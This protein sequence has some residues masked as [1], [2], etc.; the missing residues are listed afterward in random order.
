MCFA[1]GLHLAVLDVLYKKDV[2]VQVSVNIEAEEIDDWAEDWADDWAEDVDGIGPE[3][4]E[5]FTDSIMQ[6]KTPNVIFEATE[7]CSIKQ[8]IDKIRQVVKRF[9]VSPTKN[10][11]IL[12]VR[13]LECHKKNLV[14]M[15]DCRT[16]WNSTLS[17]IRR[18]LFMRKSIS[19]ALVDSG[20]QINFTNYEWDLM[21][22]IVKCLDPIEIAIK[23]LCKSN[24]SLVKADLIFSTLLN[25]IPTNGE[26]EGLMHGAL[27]TRINQRRNMTSI[28]L[29]FLHSNN[30]IVLNENLETAN[31]SEISEFLSSLYKRTHPSAE[32]VAEEREDSLD[33][34]IFDEG[35]D[36]EF[37][38]VLNK[39]TEKAFA[40]NLNNTIDPHSI[41]DNIKKEMDVFTA[42][43]SKGSMLKFC[44]EALS[45]IQP[46]SCENE[47]N[48]SAAG[49]I[50]NKLSTR[51]G[52]KSINALTML[53]GHFK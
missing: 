31:S 41:T 13:V 27:V 14:L 44:Y 7:A 32:P 9:R 51:L 3:E 21:K 30:Q 19:L 20:D 26:F 10:D 15:L 40:I 2:Q 18:F 52:D 36:L 43:G 42:T 11:S 12:Q 45:T 4:V 35:E 16:R 49:L 28:A 50:V 53:K 47:R 39:T 5:E 23:S 22:I 1:H 48:F 29:M 33:S 17:M 37:E 46:T 38:A 34:I 6:L 24:T 25:A 8:L